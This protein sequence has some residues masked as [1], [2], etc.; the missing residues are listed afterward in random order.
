MDMP[1]TIAEVSEDAAGHGHG[2]LFLDF[3]E[4]ART[5]ASRVAQATRPD[6]T[7]RTSV[8]RTTIR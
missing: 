8:F 4:V 2:R 5:Y 1:R 3:I 6:R 7:Q